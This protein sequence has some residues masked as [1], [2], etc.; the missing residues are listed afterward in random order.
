MTSPP[1]ASGSSSASTAS[2]SPPRPTK[3]SS[4]SSPTGRPATWT[5]SILPTASRSPS[6]PTR[7]AAR[8]STS[9]AADGAG[10][11][12]KV[13]DLDT[14][15]TSLVWSPDS[16][17]IAFTTSDRKL[18]TIGADG[19]NLKELASSQ[20]RPDRQPDL[21]AGR[22][23]DRLFQDRRLPVERHLP[24][25]Q[26]PAA[27]R[28][29]SRSTRPARRTPASRPMA[30]RSTSSAA[31]GRWRRRRTRR[32]RRSSACRWRSSPGIPTSPISA[33]D[34]RV[35]AGPEMRRAANGGA[36]RSRQDAE[37]RLGRSESGAP[38][39][40]RGR[41]RSSTTSPATTARR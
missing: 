16:K 31:K 26:Q 24:D 34:G 33:P 28:R 10:P 35:G 23:A 7:A 11:A 22:Q 37:D 13:T 15:K 30:R 6:S 20:L 36:G 27:R 8:R 38:G 5:S 21:V 25:P 4:A 14:L 18:F 39:R 17:S 40:S 19:K 3:A 1:T 29:R 41:R 12:R 2:S 9:I 32:R